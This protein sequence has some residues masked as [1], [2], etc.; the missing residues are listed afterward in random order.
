MAMLECY[1][2]SLVAWR[3]LSRVADAFMT[4]EEQD[5]VD[6]MN[7]L[8]RPL[9]DDPPIVAGESGGAGLAGLTRALSDPAA[10]AALKLDK[11]SRIL[12][13]NAEGATDPERY[14]ELVGIPFT[15]VRAGKRVVAAMDAG[16]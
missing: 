1:E 12:V 7:R 3:I 9:R 8:A 4:L 16:L 13:I 10:K 11:T 15:E 2:P 5:A 14:L 6:V